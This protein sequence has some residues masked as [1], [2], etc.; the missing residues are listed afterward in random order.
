MEASTMAKK[1]ST[2]TR[3]AVDAGAWLGLAAA[4]TFALMA[5]L[6]A[7]DAP[8]AAMC[9]SPPGFLPID[10]M[11]WMYLLMALFHVPPWLELASRPS[12]RTHRFIPQSKGN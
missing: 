10:A 7:A 4:P 12:R 1:R 8:H 3:K 2:R 5:W 11:S 6:S 9:S